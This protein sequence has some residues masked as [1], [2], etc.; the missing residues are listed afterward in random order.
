MGA[1]AESKMT[2]RAARKIESIRGGKFIGIAIRS[3]NAK[4]QISTGL[5]SHVADDHA[6][7][8]EP[9][10]QLVGALEAQELLDC[11]A[12]QVRR[13]AQL[14]QRARMSNQCVEAV[15]DQVRRCLVTRIQQKDTVVKQLGFRHLSRAQQPGQHIL[16]I[17]GMTAPVRH[18]NAQVIAEL[19]NRTVSSHVLIGCQYRLQCSEYRQGPPAQWRAIFPWNTQ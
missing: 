11:G 19:A 17:P 8:D 1:G 4:S 7:C 14:L 10:A 9:V 6:L 5:E 15:S 2:V 16:F 3:S 13:L 12:D 18:Q